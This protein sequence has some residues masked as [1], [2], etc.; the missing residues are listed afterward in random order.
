M[1]AMKNIMLA[2]IFLLTA[3]AAFAQSAPPKVLAF[4][5]V[6]GE[7]DHLMYAQEAAKVFGANAAKEGYSFATTSDWDAMNDAN[8]K[9]VRLVI[10]LNDQ[11]HTDAQRAAFQRYME[12]GGRWM[13]F[14]ISGLLRADWPW[15]KNF[16]GGMTFGASN[17]PSLPARVNIE[18]AAHPVTR[19]LPSSFVAPI[20]E[21]YTW[22]PSPRGNP[23]IHVLMSLDK[24]N[25]PLGIKNVINAPDLP[26]AWTNTKYRMVYFNYGHGDQIYTKPELPRMTDNAL[27]WL[28][29]Q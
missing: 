4:F 25:F 18:D 21:W 24:S 27:H 14:H 20:N 19:G 3:P 7:I 2:F 1:P 8:L 26:V 12:N 6:S 28:L 17:W 11:P 15:Y 5:T 23:A 16:L 29:K 9:D 10:F 13:G 22:S